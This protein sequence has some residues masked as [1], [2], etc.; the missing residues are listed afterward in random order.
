[1]YFTLG[2]QGKTAYTLTKKEFLL[3]PVMQLIIESPTVRLKELKSISSKKSVSLPFS[4]NDQ[5]SHEE[6]P[7]ETS[8]WL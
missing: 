3:S 1:V 6:F 8:N 5:T 4:Q 7:Y 2:T